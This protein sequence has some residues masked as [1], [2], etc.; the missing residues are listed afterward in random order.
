MFHR[1]GD[2][3]QVELVHLVD[4]VEGLAGGLLEGGT[5]SISVRACV[6]S[7]AECIKAREWCERG[8]TRQ[9]VVSSNGKKHTVNFAFVF[10]L[11]FSALIIAWSNYERV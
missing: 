7:F 1:K 5:R 2:V 8:R 10:T 4:M 9:R 6:C 3:L 11:F